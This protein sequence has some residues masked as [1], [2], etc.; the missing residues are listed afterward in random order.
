VVADHGLDGEGCRGGQLDGLKYFGLGFELVDGEQY[1]RG[2]EG[3]FGVGWDVVVPQVGGWPVVRGR[4]GGCDGVDE[5]G[6]SPDPGLAAVEVAVW[7]EVGG[8]GEEGVECPASL[9]SAFGGCDER[10]PP[11][12]GL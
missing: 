5:E 4:V 9:E 2:G 3:E 10:R 1:V 6:E 11:G 8:F 12:A 7:A